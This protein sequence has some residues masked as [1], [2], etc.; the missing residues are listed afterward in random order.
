M[1]EKKE[2]SPAGSTDS[3][4]RRQSAP[5]TEAKSKP[6]PTPKAGPKN[7]DS[8]PAETDEEEPSD[9]VPKGKSWEKDILSVDTIIRDADDNGLYALL[10]WTNGKRS[11]V[12]I[13]SCYEK[14]PRAML[15][16][17]E[18]HLQVPPPS[19]VEASA[20]LVYF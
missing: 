1:G 18:T 19:F 8:T 6:D 12:P 5:K 13:A 3:K 9:W 2:A 14:C 7:V 17:Y 11:R 15:Q 4:R 20:D 16:F 10:H